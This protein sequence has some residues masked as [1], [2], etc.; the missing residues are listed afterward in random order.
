MNP[1]LFSRAV[2]AINELE[3]DMILT[4]SMNKNWMIVDPFTRRKLNDMGFKGNF[5]FSNNQEIMKAIERE[6]HEGPFSHII[7]L[8]HKE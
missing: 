8:F 5:I 4:T 2:G 6:L 1:E 3:I 7:L